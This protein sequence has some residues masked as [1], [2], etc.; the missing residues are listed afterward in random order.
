MRKQAEAVKHI[1]ELLEARNLKIQ[2][3][4]LTLEDQQKWIIFQHQDKQ[5]GIDS[6]SG[7]WIRGSV[8]DDWRCLSMPC[9]VSGALQA[10]DFL[11]K[12]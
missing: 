7:V 2:L 8:H 11:T 12:D 6:V 9:N 3:R 10:V 1:R 5:I 4:T